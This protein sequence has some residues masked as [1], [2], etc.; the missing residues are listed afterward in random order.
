MNISSK[1]ILVLLTPI[2][3][4]PAATFAA[5]V[6]SMSLDVFKDGPQRVWEVSV[7]CVGLTQPRVMHRP[8]DSDQWCSSDI[9]SLCDKNKFS[10][11]RQL[12]SDNFSQQVTDFKSGMP[13]SIVK[14]D[15]IDSNPIAEV[16][17]AEKV[18]AKALINVEPTALVNVDSKTLVNVEPKTP[19]TSKAANGNDVGAQ[20]STP[21]KIP[22]QLVS[23]ENLLKEQMQIEE[24]RILIE[25]KRLELRRKQLELQ[26]RQLNAS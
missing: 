2:W 26:K 3:S 22:K 14:A 12:C 25:Q 18:A 7:K 11:S 24:Q 4:F 15:P 10:L 23:K 8:L 17:P 20:A 21:S 9:G 5:S 16:E 6:D 13:V 1:L 19:S